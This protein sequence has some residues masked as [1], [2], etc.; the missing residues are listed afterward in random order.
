[1]TTRPDFDRC[2]PVA[3]PVTADVDLLCCL[4]PA[5]P[6]LEATDPARIGRIAA[7]LAD[8]FTRLRGLTRAVSLFGSAR[9]SEDHPD[10]V[11]ARRT[12]AELGRAGFAIITGGGPGV[13]AAANRG[14]RDAGVLSVGL[15]IE[16]PAEQLINP[17]VDLPVMFRHFFVRKLMFARFSA[18]FVLF[19]GGFGT[20]DELF[21]MLTLAQTGKAT[22]VPVVLVGTRHW[23]G[24]VDWIGQHLA[25]SGM[26]GGTDLG[27][28]QLTDEP[29]QVV[30]WVDE[31]WRAQPRSLPAPA[32]PRS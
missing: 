25:P 23:R 2:A 11:L 24:L 17:Y 9:L 6:S 19:P 4:G 1:M 5:F 31:A 20:L 32:Q 13:M 7:E 18:A 16:L 22:R 14:A 12:A 8:G 10:C 30:E 3:T 15:D 26:I 28:I 27:R 21:E 29:G